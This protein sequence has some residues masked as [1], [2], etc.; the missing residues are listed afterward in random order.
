MSF[1]SGALSR[2]ATNAMPAMATATTL[3][4][5]TG[6]GKTTPRSSR[7]HRRPTMGQISKP[8]RRAER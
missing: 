7:A 1:S 5:T 8:R 4:I 2:V 3:R 6:E